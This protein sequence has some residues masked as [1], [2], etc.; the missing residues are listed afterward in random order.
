MRMG[1]QM[2]AILE[3]LAIKDIGTDLGQLISALDEIPTVQTMFGSRLDY[4]IKNVKYAS[5]SRSLRTLRQL[6]LIRKVR[7]V[8]KDT[9]ARRGFSIDRF[10]CITERGLQTLNDGN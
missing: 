3:H 2:K 5:F 10:Y 9:T 8:R 7:Q 6:G 1:K 4:K